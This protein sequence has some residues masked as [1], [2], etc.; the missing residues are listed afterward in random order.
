MMVSAT[1]GERNRMRIGFI[2]TQFSGTD[3]VSLEAGRWSDVFEAAGHDCFWFA[4]KSARQPDASMVVSQAHSNH[5]EIKSINT[6][7]FGKT[8]RDPETTETIHRL[9]ALLKTRLHLFITRY[10]LDLLVVANA[11]TIPLNIPLG[12]AITETVAETGIPTIAHHHDFA[13]ERDRYARSG[14]SDY[15]RMA[16][17]PKLP[18]IEH[19]VINS[20]AREE[21]AHRHGISST[22]IPN[23]TVLRDRIE[24]I[25]KNLFGGSIRPDAETDRPDNVVDF[26]P[27]VIHRK[28]AVL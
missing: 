2:S 24:T 26:R 10:R 27:S 11:V 25:F 6:R 3:G 14:I 1:G 13:R 16:F 18:N 17:P 19:V 28:A 21:L 12:L 9:R 4:G 7:V 8:G 15:L 20:T 5:P 22:V 23:V